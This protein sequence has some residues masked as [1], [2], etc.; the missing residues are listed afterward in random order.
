MPWR[1]VFAAVVLVSTLTAQSTNFFSFNLT[2]FAND[3]LNYGPARLARI[4]GVDSMVFDASGN[5]YLAEIGM[6]RRITPDGMI[7]PL[8]SPVPNQLGPSRYRAMTIDPD[9]NLF[10][11]HYVDNSTFEVLRLTPAGTLET[12]VEAGAIPPSTLT[13]MA[14][15]N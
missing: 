11:L 14:A 6:I 2:S 13:S 15:G 1:A 12:W 9:G 7:A 10:F 5:L 4:S 8:R 3:L